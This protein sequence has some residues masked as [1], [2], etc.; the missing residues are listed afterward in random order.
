MQRHPLYPALPRQRHQRHEVRVVRVH[1]TV[2]Q[3]SE[4]VERATGCGNAIARLHQ[5]AVLKKAAVLDRTADPHEILHHNPP[6]TQ[7]EVANLTVAHLSV[8]KSNGASRRG[9]QRA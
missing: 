7:I 1:A 6:G 5:C 9:Q 4:Q 3:Q 2:T 8:G